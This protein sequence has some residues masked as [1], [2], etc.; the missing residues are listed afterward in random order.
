[1]NSRDIY[2]YLEFVHIQ[3]YK[4][5]REDLCELRGR[6]SDSGAVSEGL[7]QEAFAKVERSMKMVISSLYFT[8]AAEREG[9]RLD[10]DSR[11]E[12]CLELRE[13]ISNSVFINAR[14]IDSSKVEA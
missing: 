6:V 13:T 2:H 11:R 4:T 7:K 14:H 10:E 9:F 5:M 12:H 3:D 1:M 8:I